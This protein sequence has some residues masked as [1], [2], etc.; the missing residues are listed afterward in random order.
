MSQRNLVFVSQGFHK[1]SSHR[2]KDTQTQP[3]FVFHIKCLAY[4][5]IEPATR[6]VLRVVRGDLYHWV[7]RTGF[8][9]LK[10]TLLGIMD[11]WQDI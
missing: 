11:L 1:H 2:H 5:D 4:A 6:R 10:T 3:A 7:F 9:I 8:R